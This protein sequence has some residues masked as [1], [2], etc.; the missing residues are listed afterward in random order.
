MGED[1]GHATRQRRQRGALR[2][3]RAS[4]HEEA[5]EGRGES[6]ES[7]QKVR[8]VLCSVRSWKSWLGGL[9]GIRGRFLLQKERTATTARE[10]DLTLPASVV[11][12]NEPLRRKPQWAW[13]RGERE[14]RERG[15]G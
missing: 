5:M 13:R 4:R 12:K 11:P 15:R 7:E 9:V 3:C 10:A 6:T 8:R 2:E 1:L 14:E